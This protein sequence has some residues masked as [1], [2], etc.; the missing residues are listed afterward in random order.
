MELPGRVAAV[1]VTVNVLVP[2]PPEIFAGLK[3]AVAPAGS[4]DIDNA[5]GPEN[6]PKGEIVTVDV[7]LDAAFKEA[8]AE[9]AIPKSDVTTSVTG[10]AEFTKLLPVPMKLSI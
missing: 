1:V 5:T 7:V 9:A 4:P 3:T 10:G 6:P 2:E 8:N